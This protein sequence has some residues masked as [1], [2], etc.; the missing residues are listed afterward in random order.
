[1]CFQGK[2]NRTVFNK[3]NRNIFLIIYLHIDDIIFYANGLCQEFLNVMSKDI[4][5]SMAG[6]LNFLL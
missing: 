5:M 3:T 4:E 2:I 6:E 1:M